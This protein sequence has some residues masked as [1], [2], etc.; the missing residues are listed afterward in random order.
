MKGAYEGAETRT[1]AS[2]FEVGGR[3]TRE[4]ERAPPV[5]TEPRPPPQHRKSEDGLVLRGRRAGHAW[6]KNGTAV[7]TAQLGQEGKGGLANLIVIDRQ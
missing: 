3:E 1:V 5:R 2:Q 4:S 7:R 6:K